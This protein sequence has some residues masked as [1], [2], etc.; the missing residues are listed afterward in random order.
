MHDSW[1]YHSP[2]DVIM[3]FLVLYITFCHSR[4]KYWCWGNHHLSLLGKS[5]SKFL[6]LK[7]QFLLEILPCFTQNHS[8]RRPPHAD[9]R[10][11]SPVSA[12]NRT[13]VAT[14]LR[15]ARGCQA[16]QHE[17]GPKGETEARGKACGK[18]C[19]SLYHE[20]Y[21]EANLFME[22]NHELF[23][24]ISPKYGEEIDHG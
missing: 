6:L 14:P 5:K 9:G 23:F 8:C 17:R 21:H 7:C 20:L 10:T 3:F 1:S 4:V 2:N 18:L 22:K 15:P 19:I 16:E 24:I 12:Q 13:A 11:T